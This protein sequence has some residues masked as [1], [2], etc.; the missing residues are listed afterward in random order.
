MQTERRKLEHIMICLQKDVLHDKTN[1]FEQ[2]R[3]IPGKPVRKEDVNLSTEFLEA[4]LK[5]PLL[6]EAMT[7]GAAGTGVINRN[8]AAAAE[9]LGIGMGVGSQRAAIENPNVLDT[10]QVRSEAPGILLLGNLG[11][12]QVVK[13]PISKIVDAVKSI[14]ADA[15]AVHINPL[16]EIAQPEGDADAQDMMDQL[17]DRI[18]EI[19]ETTS[20]KIVAKE[21]GFGLNEIMAA[22]L[23]EAGVDA[24]DVA[25]AGG[26]S[27]IK[28][29]QYR[30]SKSLDGLLGEG[31]PTAESLRQCASV[32][33]PIIASGGIRTGEE[34]A[35][36]L[37]MGASLAGAALPFLK[38]ALES[39]TAV[40][41]VAQKMI[42]ELKETMAFVGAKSVSELK[43]R[44][45]YIR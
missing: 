37:A 13:Y 17:F 1:G 44:Y 18:K 30:G 23:K 35:K 32:G 6:I 34:I 43:G 24:I 11:M 7:G 14:G 22:K 16:Q 33:V 9:E 20:L 42:D 3:L 39:S 28:I 40:G 8:L 5:A 4:K 45:K 36:S 38:P 19:K 29:E 26:T 41:L 21:V 10:F 2:I 25:G 12:A 15:L 27:W 31:I